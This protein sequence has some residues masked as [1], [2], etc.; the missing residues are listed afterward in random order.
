MVSY[1]PADR[2]ELKRTLYT[3]NF[4]VVFRTNISTVLI[5]VDPLGLAISNFREGEAFK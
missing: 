2:S 4:V 1:S 5:P 3:A